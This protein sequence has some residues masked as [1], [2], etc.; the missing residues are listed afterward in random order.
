MTASM[1]PGNERGM[2]MPERIKNGPAVPMEKFEFEH[3]NS[4]SY[5][6]FVTNILYK[7][8]AGLAVALLVSLGFNAWFI[9]KSQNVKII[10]L[11]PDMRVVPVQPL[12]KPLLTPAGLASY[13]E[14]TLQE[15]LTFNYSN[16]RQVLA[17]QQHNFS[18][19]AFGA[20]WEGMKDYLN[21]IESTQ[22]IITCTVQET[23][24]VLSSRVENGRYV[25]VVETRIVIAVDNNAFGGRGRNRLRYVVKT[26]IVRADPTRVQSGAVID[27]IIFYPD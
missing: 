2:R 19:E 12:D 8:L 18:P 4:V 3:E 5:L 15:T 27:K 25:W 21:N 16:Y 23:P 20:I 22:S 24:R 7:L 10:A 13:V 1:V 26:S 14:R 17:T 6:A 9:Y 11:T